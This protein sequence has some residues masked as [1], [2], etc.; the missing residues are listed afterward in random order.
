MS[1]VI[2]WVTMLCDPTQIFRGR[3]E[4]VATPEK[5][6]MEGKTRRVL[7]FGFKPAP[8]QLNFYNLMKIRIVL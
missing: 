8:F 7:S 4:S 6:R 1:R 2:F 3:S 5:F